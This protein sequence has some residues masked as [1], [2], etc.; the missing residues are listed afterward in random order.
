MP[1][2]GRVFIEGPS[3]TGKSSAAAA[4]LQ[5]M[6]EA[7]IPGH[8]I[9]MLVPQRTLAYPY[10]EVMGQPVLPPGT[11][12]DVFTLGGLA[13]RLVDLFWPMLAR[14]AGFAHPDRPPVFLNVETA[15]YYMA[16]IVAPL[17][18]NEG[19]FQS[20]TIDANRLYSQILSNLNSA[21][22]IGFPAAEISQRLISAWQGKPDQVRIYQ[23]AEDCALRFR[24][25]CLDHN[26]IDFS[27]VLEIFC[28]HLWP[29]LLARQ[30]LQKRYRHLIYDNIEEDIPVAHDVLHAWLPDFESALL[31]SDTQAGY[32]SFLGADPES[33]RALAGA[34]EQIV[35]FEESLVAPAELL[36]FGQMIE[37]S[38]CQPKP[39]FNVTPSTASYLTFAHDQFFPDML[40]RASQEIVRLVLREGV[41]PGD[42]A[43][44]APFLSSSLRFSLA[45]RLEGYGIPTRSHRPSRSLRDEPATQCLLTLA[46]LAHPGWGLPVSHY[47]LRSALMQSIE[48]LDLVRA[49][50]LANKVYKPNVPGSSLER[51]DQVAP[52]SQERIT[53]RIGQRYDT[54]RAW[55]ESYRAEPGLDLDIFLRRLFGEVL[56]QDGFGFHL[57]FDSANTADQLIESVQNFRWNTAEAGLGQ[58]EQPAG[59]EYVR[60]VEQG[61]LGAQYLPIWFHQNEDAVFLAPA[62]TFLVSN[63]PVRYQF[64]LDIGNSNWWRRLDQPITHAYVL[65]RHWPKEQKWTHAQEMEV[66]HEAL[67]RLVHGLVRRCSEHLYLYYTE[68]DEQGNEQQG[69]L[70]EALADILVHSPNLVVR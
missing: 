58:T 32:R 4:R 20:V 51:F 68:I 39:V 6:I 10:Y 8:S 5:A 70:F 38:L 24:Q 44:M 49:D 57:K 61:I 7:G 56:S 1:Y 52:L 35:R 30:Y 23:D 66:N 17:R 47:D 33:G 50:L 40:E 69:K 26:L 28:Q 18:D 64:W 46:K 65:S 22:G 16:R 43:V 29:S 9:L 37:D 2:T 19:Y 25:Y 41:N 42:I 55:L 34:C 21:A 36:E 31:I 53:H 14:N 54:L 60:M 3:G 63:R 59:Y 67:G 45:N 12:P 15:Q 62:F 27:L 48:D 13:R 11:M